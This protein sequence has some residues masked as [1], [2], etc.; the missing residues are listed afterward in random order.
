MGKKYENKHGDGV[1]IERRRPND[2]FTILRIDFNIIESPSCIMRS[3][4][5]E[6]RINIY[7]IGG[8]R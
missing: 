3:S 7:D 5:G 6:R 2:L 4:E 8:E 1:L